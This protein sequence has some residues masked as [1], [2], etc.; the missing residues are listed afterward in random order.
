VPFLDLPGCKLFYTSSGSGDPAIVFVHGACCAHDDWDAQ[1]AAFRRSNRVV[2]CDLRGQG[3]STADPDCCTINAHARDVGGLVSALGLRRV[4]LVGHSM[5]SRVVL[6]VAANDPVRTAAVVIVDGSRVTNDPQ[7]ADAILAALVEVQ[8]FVDAHRRT[9]EAMFLDTSPPDLRTRV[10]ERAMQVPE[11]TIKAQIRSLVRW[12]AEDFP[13]VVSSI[14]API[15]AVQSTFVDRELQRSTLAPGST[16]P[17]V[18]DLQT[19]APATEL[20]VVPGV[21]HFSMLEDPQGVIDAME[22]F[23]RR[24]S[25]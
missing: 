11:A 6:Q 7:G 9:F 4:V 21:G 24:L 16:S 18:E 12:D 1:V 20:A 10:V 17:Y 23:L 14:R 3:L 15:R 19:Y 25:G 2:A 8:D 13:G 5:G 22:P